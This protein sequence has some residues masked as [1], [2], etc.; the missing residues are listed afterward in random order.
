MPAKRV[1]ESINAIDLLTQDHRTV[2]KLYKDFQKADRNDTDALMEIVETACAELRIHSIIEE[3]IFY[4][5]LRSKLG[6]E[7]E[8]LL[9]EAAVEHEVVDEL[10]DK[11]GEIDPADS[12]YA[13]YFTVLCESAE[14]HI[15]EEE[16]EL[17]PKVRK[18]KDL[19]LEELG[20][21]MQARKD[22]LLAELEADMEMMDPEGLGVSHAQKSGETQ[23]KRP[24]R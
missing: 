23:H 22:E 1:K 13:A 9:N 18:L 24:H 11:L 14:H 20:A 6:E 15:K 4:P 7:G 10:I 12:N 16:K 2:Q 21:E 17:F 3:E 5:A 8:D 19:D